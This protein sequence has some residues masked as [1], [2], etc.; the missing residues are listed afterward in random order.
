MG[1]G[2][3]KKMARQGW[4]RASFHNSF[5]EGCPEGGWREKLCSME[6]KQDQERVCFRRKTCQQVCVLVGTT[7]STEGT[8]DAAEERGE[9]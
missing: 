9:N 1:S 8:F 3:K 6:R 4:E 5:R 7:S 2:K